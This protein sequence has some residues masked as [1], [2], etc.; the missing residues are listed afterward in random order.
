MRA[1]TYGPVAAAAVALAGWSCAGWDNPAALADLNPQVEIA[2]EAARVETLEEIEIHVHIM[3][4][5]APLA[6]HHGDLAIA[7]AAGGPA[8]VVP[9]AAEGDGYAAHVVFYQEGE[10]HIHLMAMPMRHQMAM[11]MGE[12][13]AHVHRQHRLVGP[14]WVELEVSPAPVYEDSS[15]HIH[16]FAFELLPDGTRGAAVGGLDLEA[17]V[18]QPDG[19]ETALAVVEE[20]IGEYEAAFTF[21]AAGLYELHAEIMIDGQHVAGEFHIPVHTPAGESGTGDGGGHT[22]D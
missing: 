10:H 5:G 18:H 1:V 14:Y 9:L 8:R 11:E 19:M 22:H 4:D 20:A 17:E 3:V 15:A 12:H 13:E 16:L 7:P 21:G 6:L 2:I